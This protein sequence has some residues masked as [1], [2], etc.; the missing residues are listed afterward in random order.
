MM[1]QTEVDAYYAEWERI[2]IVCY[3]SNYQDLFLESLAIITDSGSFLTE[4]GATGRPVIRLI[5]PNND[6]TPLPPSKK[7]YDTYYE[8]RTL[9]EMYAT[10]KTVLENGEDPKKDERLAA[11]EASGIARMEASKNIIDH[12][13]KIV[14]R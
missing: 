2:G 13:R 6:L 5:S 8:V 11:V 9:P 14:G 10:F 1:T 4:A 12:L 7:V 3:D